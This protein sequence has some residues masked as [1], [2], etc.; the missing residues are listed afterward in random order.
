MTN[1]LRLTLL[2]IS[3][4]AVS[5]VNS[6]VVL[7]TELNK[8]SLLSQPS[9]ASN[10]DLIAQSFPTPEDLETQRLAIQ[11]LVMCQR[12][13]NKLNSNRN[14]YQLIQL[15][16]SCIFMIQKQGLCQINQATSLNANIY[17]CDRELADFAR[18]WGGS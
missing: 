18:K 17:V 8:Q 15:Y 1:Y 5:C 2:S 7:A 4:L 12:I 11:G 13:A 9:L 6:G 14:N 10:P 3:I 16:N